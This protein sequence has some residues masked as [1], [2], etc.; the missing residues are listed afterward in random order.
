MEFIVM[1]SLFHFVNVVK[2]PIFAKNEK[3]IFLPIIILESD[4]EMNIIHNNSE[5]EFYTIIEG[6]K[7]FVSY[8]QEGNRLDIRHTVV[9][10]NLEGRGIASALVK[11]VCDYA[12]ENHLQIIA[13]CSYAVVWLER[14]PEYKGQISKDYA[15][16]GTC[17]I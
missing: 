10:K 9:P 17:A 11:Q 2:L 1:F 8:H 7:A 13:T 3:S 15:G 16:Q 6:S 12:T 4:T 5:Q 14:H